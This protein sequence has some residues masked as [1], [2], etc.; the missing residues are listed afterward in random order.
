MFEINILIVEFYL[1][2]HSTARYGVVHAIQTTQQGGFAA[3]GRADKGQHFV[4]RYVQTNPFNRLFL[5][6]IDINVA[7]TDAGVGDTPVSNRAIVFHTILFADSREN[8]FAQPG[9]I[10]MGFLLLRL[11]VHTNI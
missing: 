4:M 2:I 6:V 11:M 1:T 10:P 3:T 7:A 9:G 8:A 5:A